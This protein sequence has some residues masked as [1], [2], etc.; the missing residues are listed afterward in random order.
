MNPFAMR[1]KGSAA[2]ARGP[3]ARVFTGPFPV[4]RKGTFPVACTGAVAAVLLLGL[5]GCASGPAPVQVRTPGLIERLTPYKVEIQQGNVVTRDQVALVKPGMVREQVRE[6]LGSPMLTD[7]FHEQRWDYL[8]AVGRGSG[9]PEQRFSVAIF[10]D[11]D[12][13]Q[14]VAAPELPTENQF[15]ARMASGRAKPGPVP[16]LELTPEQRAKLPV[17]VRSESVELP[18]PQ[19]AQRAYP[20]LEPR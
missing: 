14:R 2:H 15:V 5:T 19:G 10:F 6:I 18:P 12:K 3:I 11:G 4:V 7:V 17:P 13:V 1:P 16:V 9:S 20:P 8:Y